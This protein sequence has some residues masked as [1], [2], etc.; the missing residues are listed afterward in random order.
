MAEKK[1]LIV[2]ADDFGMSPGVNQGIMTA[3][4]QGIVTSASLMVR[5]PAAKAAAAYEKEHSELSLGLHLDL[6]EWAYHNGD[7]VAVYEVVPQDDVDAVRQEVSRQIDSFR[8]LVGRNPTHIDSHQ[9]VHCREPTH[10]I[11]VEVASSLGL[12]LRHYTPK[13]RYCGNFYGQTAEGLPF[14]EAISVDGLLNILATLQPGTTELACHPGEVEH[15]ET[16]YRTER[17]QE[18][19]V[20]CDQKV[21]AAIDSSEIELA[22]FRSV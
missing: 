13:V 3:H 21:R 19:K 5:W 16:M 10:S 8:Q 17:V 6:G 11:L 20:L 22:S 18:M 15:I 2:N 4:E 7:W 1:V 14:H 12:P 9:H